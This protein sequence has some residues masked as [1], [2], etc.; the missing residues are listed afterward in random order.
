MAVIRDVEIS[1]AR[2]DLP[3]LFRLAPRSLRR[4]SRPRDSVW[5][6]VGLRAGGAHNEVMENAPRAAKAVVALWSNKSVLSH[7]VRT[8]ATLADRNKTLVTC[9]IEP[10]EQQIMFELEQTAEPSHWHA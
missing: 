4:R 10:C 7:W 8:E 1:W 2:V 9:M 5:W 6:D 3:R